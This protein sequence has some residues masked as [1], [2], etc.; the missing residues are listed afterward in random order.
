MKKL[1][2][3]GKSALWFVV[4]IAISLGFSQFRDQL[5]ISWGTLV[6]VLVVA[7]YLEYQLSRLRER[8]GLQELQTLD[9]I[10]KDDPITPAHEPSDGIAPT[11]WAITE[12]THAFFA[13]FEGFADMLNEYLDDTPWRLQQ[14]ARTDV[15]TIGDDSPTPGRRYKI[16]HGPKEAGR[17]SISEGW[18]YSR[19]HAE[20]RTV[21]ELHQARR[22]SGSQVTNLMSAFI[23]HLAEEE[24]GS[25]GRSHQIVHNEMVEAM[26]R[27]G[28]E[29]VSDSDL[30]IHLTG[31][32]SRYLRKARAD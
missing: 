17:V 27:I 13:D 5:G 31:L 9:E 18:E 6:L 2:G 14:V 11:G 24:D 12:R 19:E 25:R 21:V 1:V 20:V 28:P 10:I 22:F 8:I 3:L 16:F 26:W 7:M 4:L 30:D 29:V 32:A 15:S 23:I